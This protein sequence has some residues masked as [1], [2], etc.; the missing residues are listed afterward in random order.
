MSCLFGATSSSKPLLG[1]LLKATGS[2]AW[3]DLQVALPGGEPEGGLA[4]LTGQHES[5][6][7]LQLF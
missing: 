6:L 3:Q 7:R 2:L 5:K 1:R 4:I